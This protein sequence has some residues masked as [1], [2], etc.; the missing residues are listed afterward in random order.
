[1]VDEEIAYQ[2]LLKKEQ[3]FPSIEQEV[4]ANFEVLKKW[5]QGHPFLEWVEPVG[6]VVCFPRFKWGLPIDIEKFYACLLT[7]YKT[8]LGPGHWFEQNNRSFR[9][10]FGWGPSNAFGKGL[11]N[12][13]NAI[14]ESLS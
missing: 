5:I 11:E 4:K 1:V 13:D 12:I 6:G 9:L 2:F 3:Y 7:K 8:Y 10:G 14:K